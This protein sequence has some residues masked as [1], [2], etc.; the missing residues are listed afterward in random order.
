[1]R[2]FWLLEVIKTSLVIF[3]G[4][5]LWKMLMLFIL[6]LMSR[7]NIL[8]RIWI[9]VIPAY[10]C[11]RFLALV[12]L[13]GLNITVH[14]SQI[15]RIVSKMRYIFIVFLFLL[16]C[17]CLEVALFFLIV[18]RWEKWVVFWVWFFEKM[19]H[20]TI[21]A[22]QFALIRMNGFFDRRSETLLID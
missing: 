9:L 11:F 14:H 7:C 3:D 4:R 17:W 15:T 13:F 22:L 18:I 5:L 19:L 20:L 2:F 21:A 10:F 16:L 12:L 6:S 1:L 8:K